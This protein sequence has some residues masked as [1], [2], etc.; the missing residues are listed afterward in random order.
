MLLACC[1]Q[2]HVPFDSLGRHQVT[3]LVWWFCVPHLSSLAV[4]NPG[5][6]SVWFFDEALVFCFWNV[7]VP[8]LG[9]LGVVGGLIICLWCF[10]RLFYDLASG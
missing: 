10:L 8:L 6:F 4:Q 2:D 1:C 5:I 9:V 7:W 3:V